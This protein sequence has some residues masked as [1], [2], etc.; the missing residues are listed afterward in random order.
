MSKQTINW[1]RIL[2]Y[3]I[4]HIISYQNIDLSNQRLE[5]IQAL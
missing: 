1:Y 3:H 4:N 5:D 2:T